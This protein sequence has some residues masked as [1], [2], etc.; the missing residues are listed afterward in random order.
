MVPPSQPLG[1]TDGEGEGHE[2]SEAEENV[3][4]VKH[5]QLLQ[6]CQEQVGEDRVSGL[7]GMQVIRVK[8]A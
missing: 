6:V 1:G 3:E 8:N 7:W 4:K 2:I 5:R